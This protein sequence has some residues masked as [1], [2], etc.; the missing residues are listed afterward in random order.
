MKFSDRHCFLFK[1]PDYQ[2]LTRQRCTHN[3]IHVLVGEAAWDVRI[4]CI[5]FD[6]LLMAHDRLMISS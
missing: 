6:P 1:G 4:D 2:C 3:L 5:D